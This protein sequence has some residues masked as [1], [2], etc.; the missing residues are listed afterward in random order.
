MIKTS[1]LIILSIIFVS[2]KKLMYGCEVIRNK[3]LNAHNDYN[4]E[5]V[6]AF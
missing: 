3:F 5:W 1:I 2:S 6:C 4:T